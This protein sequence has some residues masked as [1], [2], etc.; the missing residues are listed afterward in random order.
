M[1]IS[2]FETRPVEV[3]KYGTVSSNMHKRGFAEY[4]K[5]TREQIPTGTYIFSSRSVPDLER[6]HNSDAEKRQRE[7]HQH[8]AS[9]FDL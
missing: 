9:I 2:S 6:S 4:G 5:R 3:K 1:S 7:P 8:R